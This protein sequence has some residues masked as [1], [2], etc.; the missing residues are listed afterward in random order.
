MTSRIVIKGKFVTGMICQCPEHG[1]RQ[2]ET[3]RKQITSH[4]NYSNGIGDH[5]TKYVF[6][7][8]AINAR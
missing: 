6:R 3:D 7:G 8:C 1:M 2:P 4:D 5:V